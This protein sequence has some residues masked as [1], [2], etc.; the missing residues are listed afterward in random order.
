MRRGYAQ[1]GPVARAL[2]VTGDRWTILI[3]QDLL[4]GYHRFSQIR[5]SVK[6]IASNVLSERLKLLEGHGV[7]ERRFY[8]DHPPRAEYHLTRKGHELGI[9]AG[10]LAAWGAKYFSDPT[11]LVHQ[12]CG[13][14]VT[15]VY[16][17]PACGVQVRGAEVRLVDRSG[18]PEA[19]DVGGGRSGRE[20]APPK[21]LMT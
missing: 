8:S 2:G 5:A 18:A 17:C 10:A 20:D 14:P 16:Q 6:G 9:V 3:L 1:P 11:V 19:E 12:Q 13:S 4:R 7:V 15:V 21:Y